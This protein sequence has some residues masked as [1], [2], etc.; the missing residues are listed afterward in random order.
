[1][2]RPWYAV[3]PGSRNMLITK[4]IVASRGF[5]LEGAVRNGIRRDEP[6]ERVGF[7]A[8]DGALL[9]ILDCSFKHS[10]AR[11]APVNAL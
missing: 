8:P 9:F 1:M 4:L 7:T 5:E 6:P 10:Y 11:R 2:L 3:H